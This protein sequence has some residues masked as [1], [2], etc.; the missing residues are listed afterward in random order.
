MTKNLKKLFLILMLMSA[1][2]CSTIPETARFNSAEA[3]KPIGK[4][5][6]IFI[7]GMYMT[8][9][10]WKN[11]LPVFQNEKF[12]AV[13]PAWPLHEGSV[14]ELRADAKR[15]AQLAKLSLEDVLNFYREYIKSLPQKPVLIG[16]SM[17]GLIAQ[18]LASEGLASA[19]IAINSAAPNGMIPLRWSFF[20]SNWAIFNPFVNTESPL[21][22]DLAQFSYGFTNTQNESEQK[23]AF[24]NFYVH[25]S[26]HLGRGA[27][28]SAGDI[29]PLQLKVPLLLIA[30]GRDN[31]IP[32]LLSYRNFNFYRESGARVEYKLFAERD[33]FTIAAPGWESVAAYSL[34]WLKQLD[35]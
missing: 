19:A 29:D 7:H 33:H 14:S 21:T 31:I 6:L 9:E 26:R 4:P 24:E 27:L 17:G 23:Q 30:G 32:D 8:S 3:V 13:S 10:S 34:N 18:K 1:F 12:S 25:E 35:N 16:H 28:S 15:S 22:L 11:W 20:R 5:L 2:A